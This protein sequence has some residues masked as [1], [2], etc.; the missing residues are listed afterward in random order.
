[1]VVIA[2]GLLA[3]HN[4]FT[5]PFILD[6]PLSISKNPTIRHLW[7]LS[8]VLSP[9]P[10]GGVTVE[11]RP[12][13]N[14]SLAINYAF[15]GTRV[16]GYHALNLTIHILAGLTLF[17][18]VRRTLL[19]P[20]LRDHYGAVASE[21]A[22][23]SAIIWMLHPLQTESVTYV[24]QRAESIAGLF[25][26][27]TLYCF[28]RG[29]GSPRPR[30]WYGLCLSACVLGVASK[31]VLASAPLLVMVYDRALISGSFREA[32]R[33]RSPLYIGLAGTWILLAC[34]LFFQRSLGNAL[35]YASTNKISQWQYL[36][37]EPGVILHY[38]R[39]AFWPDRL[40]FDYL[41][42]PLA[43]AWPGVLPAAL[44]IVALLA[45]TAWALKANSVWGIA[46]AWFF[47]ILAPSSSFIPLDCPAYEHRM[48]LPLAAV[49]VAAV[50]AIH[51]LLG[52][53]SR[54]VFVAIAIVL[55][56]LTA[57]RNADYRSEIA[58]WLDTVEKW[59]VNAR[60]NNNL[61]TALQQAGRSD[62]AMRYFEQAIRIKPDYS[63]AYNNLGNIF[64]AQD[65]LE[66]AFGQYK[67]AL[68]I[69]PK[70]AE[71][72]NNLGIVLERTGH[73][74]EAIRQFEESI[75]IRPET[76]EVHNNLGNALVA[77]GRLQE[78]IG[79]F[80]EAVK[81]KPDFAEASSNLLFALSQQSTSGSS[82]A[83][84]GAR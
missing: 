43:K 1:L 39:L 33:R 23:A 18:V 65:R 24:I 48:Y 62:E 49:I 80:E 51:A 7:P 41:G 59:P 70:H 21:L 22:L 28:I 68:R 84:V 4:S 14:F 34:L 67:Q 2:A 64:L 81:L 52:Q 72:H 40:C 12:L 26:L 32:W 31:E 83:T 53:R 44:V 5:G 30:V 3:Y 25:Y 16:W 10:M 56:V 45:A 63:D 60:A 55:G 8:Q 77:V 47:L 76:A 37:T 54:V 69:Q 20:R 50:L 46:G 82:S 74:E 66:E 11:G 57:Q 19:Q 79:Q 15:G 36:G 6:D 58:I 17:G 29:V 61:G 75:R 13:L 78:G 35:S 71:A 73:I 38:L 42:W 9:P 27:L